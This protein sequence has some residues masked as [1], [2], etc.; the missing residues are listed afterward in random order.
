[1]ERLEERLSK[2][3]EQCLE[4]DKAEHEKESVTQ[5]LVLVTANHEVLLQEHAKVLEENHRL[6]L[7]MEIMRLQ[8]EA[9]G[10]QPQVVQQAEA[11]AVL[12]QA[13][14]KQA[15]KA[16]LNVSVTAPT[17]KQE[18]MAKE[19][20]EKPDSPEADTEKMLPLPEELPTAEEV[21]AFFA[22]H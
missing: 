18:V 19:E 12:M 2:S 20:Q 11:P 9:M 5:Q 7:E 3:K 1:M 17:A 13:A 6:K 4:E 22:N 8:M 14:G 21:V 16:A 15:K 10:Q